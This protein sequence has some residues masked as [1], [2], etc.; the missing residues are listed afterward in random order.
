MGRSGD[1]KAKD[2][3]KARSCIL[4]R[5]DD[6][7]PEGDLMACRRP[8]FLLFDKE[9]CRQHILA[10]ACVRQP[11]LDEACFSRRH[12]MLPCIRLPD[13]APVK[14]EREPQIIAARI[15]KEALVL[16]L[17]TFP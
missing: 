10:F 3:Q 5:H 11:I 7:L 4:R 1:A 15:R 14:E 9:R 2:I 8:Y 16:D 13:L 17:H 6:R 12:I